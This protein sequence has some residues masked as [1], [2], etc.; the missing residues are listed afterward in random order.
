M[1]RGQVNRERLEET[2]YVALSYFVGPGGAKSR[3]FLNLYGGKGKSSKRE[4]LLWGAIKK[5]TQGVDH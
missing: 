1:A 2:M 4:E 5:T 3:G